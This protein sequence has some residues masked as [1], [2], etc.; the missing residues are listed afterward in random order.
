MVANV[1]KKG[2]FAIGEMVIGLYLQIHSSKSVFVPTIFKIYLPPLAGR[3]VDL[4]RNWSVDW[5]KKE[6]V[7]ILVVSHCAMEKIKFLLVS[8][9]C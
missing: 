9:V 1:L 5:G 3:G 8:V 7:S 2:S 6:K 4:N